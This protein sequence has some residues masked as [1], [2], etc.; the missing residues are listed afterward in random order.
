M[1]DFAAWHEANDKYLSD[2]MVWL[3]ARLERLA[4][5]VTPEP[6]TMERDVV[7]SK[8]PSRSL[9]GRVLKPAPSIAVEHHALPPPSEVSDNESELPPPPLVDMEQLDHSPALVLLANRFGLTAFERNVLLLCAAMELDT[10]TASLCARAQRDPAKLYPTF[11]LA[12]TLFDESAWDVMSPERPLRYWRLIEINQPGALPLTASALRADERIVNYIKGLMNYLDDRLMPLLAPLSDTADDLPPSQQQQADIIVQHMRS[13]SRGLPVVHLLGADSASKRSIAKRAAQELGLSVYRLGADML[14][15]AYAELETLARLYR[16]ESQLLPVALYIDAQDSDK[17]PPAVNRFLAKM[18]GLVFLDIRESWPQL[19]RDALTLDVAKPSSVEQEQAWKKALDEDAGEGPALLAGQFNLNLPEIERIAHTAKGDEQPTFDRVWDACLIASRPRLDTLAQRLEMKAQT[20][21]GLVLPDPEKKLL[22]QI[23]DQ[24]GQRHHVYERWGF[25]RRMSR[26]LGISALFA[27]E[28]GTGKT[29]AA[30]VIAHELKL[31]L[32]RI[33]L[34]QVV[35]K[36]I[37]ETEKNL[38]KL[39][40]AAEDG[41]TILFFDEAD[42]LFGKRSEVK[43]SHDR[44][45]N[46][47]INYLLQRMEAYRGLAILATNMKSALDTAFMRRLRFIVNF[48]FPGVPERK[49][50]WERVFPEETEKEGLDHERLARFNLT[51]GSIQNIAINAAFLA[52]SAG[53]P[54]TMPL[55]FD[56]ARSEF[57]KLEKPINEAEFRLIQVVEAKA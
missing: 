14:P 56:A 26:G 36:Y 12:L 54:V 4:E 33:D 7:S 39:F 41:G 1:S 30:E 28:S 46:I 23:M 8:P 19:G 31:N 43:D 44:Y 11:A 50:I 24:V 45:A 21:D 38:R 37:G 53:S 9:F 34:S 22:R 32:Y 5:Q 13:A 29:L 48:P 47:E 51:G 57:R 27:G 16:R 49:R 10:R 42:A 15:A 55:I 52:A 40:D 18:S 2:A 3:R 6:P 17:E 35:N 25:S 20:W